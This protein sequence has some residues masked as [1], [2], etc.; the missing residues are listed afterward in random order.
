MHQL[1]H[2]I[3]AVGDLLVLHV[4]DVHGKGD[5]LIHRH[6]RDEAEILEDDAHLTA[7]IGHLM[8]AQVGNVLAQ[9]G[10]LA[11]G[12]GLLPQD[13]LQQGGFAR[14]GMAQQK[15]ELAFVHV[16]VDV[17]QRQRPA[18]FIFL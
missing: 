9:H 3:H 18:L 8:A 12:G 17:F 14:A 16:E 15:H 5:V 1:Q 7:Q 10:H 6:G 13:E 4:G 2:V 11:L